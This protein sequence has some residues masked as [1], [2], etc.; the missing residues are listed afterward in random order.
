MVA[1]ALAYG[2]AGAG[3]CERRAQAYVVLVYQTSV[4]VIL[5]VLPM[6]QK[7]APIL[8][9]YLPLLQPMGMLTLMLGKKQRSLFIILRLMVWGFVYIT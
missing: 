4:S 7:V 5:D 2:S 3:V 9:M 8:P 6:L 1:Q